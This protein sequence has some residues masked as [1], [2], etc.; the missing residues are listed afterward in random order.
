MQAISQAVCVKDRALDQFSDRRIEE[1]GRTV[2]LVERRFDALATLVR[3]G[4]IRQRCKFLTPTGKYRRW[5]TI[6]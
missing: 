5:Q 3:G 1:H 6:G 4:I 2:A